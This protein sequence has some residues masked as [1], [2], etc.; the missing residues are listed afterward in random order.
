MMCVVQYKIRKKKNN[1]DVM[2]YYFHNVTNIMLLHLFSF[3]ST[4]YIYI[5]IIYYY[6]CS[7]KMIGQ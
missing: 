3:I 5:Y 1:D 2:R 6:Y 7:N 4:I